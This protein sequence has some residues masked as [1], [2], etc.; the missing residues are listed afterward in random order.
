MEPIHC[1]TQTLNGSMSFLPP[2]PPC[3]TCAVAGL[4]GLSL[5]GSWGAICCLRHALRGTHGSHV[6]LPDTLVLPRCW[7]EKLHLL[8]ANRISSTLCSSSDPLRV[9]HDPSGLQTH[10]SPAPDT[11]SLTLVTV[12]WPGDVVHLRDCPEFYIICLCRSCSH[13][14]CVSFALPIDA[15]DRSHIPMEFR[16][17]GLTWLALQ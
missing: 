7:A 4:L 2:D 9:I 14:G 13:P 16:C 6:E 12:P 8:H 15:M 1:I 3:H 5:P 10:T 11:Q 17:W